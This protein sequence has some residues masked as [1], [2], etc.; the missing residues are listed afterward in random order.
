MA[1][2]PDGHAVSDGPDAVR[3][4]SE[5]NE[6]TI[7]AVEARIVAREWSAVV[8]TDLHVEAG[9]VDLGL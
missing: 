7:A 2:F 4:V 8:D 3:G 1:A 5:F 6:H 9:P